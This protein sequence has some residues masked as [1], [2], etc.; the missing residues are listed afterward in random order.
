[1]PYDHQF[2]VFAKMERGPLW[3]G[4]FTDLEAAK[5]SADKLARKEGFEFF[6][7]SFKDFSEVARYFPI[8]PKGGVLRW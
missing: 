1:M 6:V 5:K 7:F 3:S 8:R 4:F 2:A